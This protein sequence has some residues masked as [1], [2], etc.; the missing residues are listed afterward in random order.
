[1]FYKMKKFRFFI[2]L[3][4]LIFSK[5][6]SSEIIEI[7]SME[8]IQPYIDD[9]TLVV[10]DIDNTLLMTKQMLGG[11]QWFEHMLKKYLSEEFSITESI[12]KALPLYMEIQNATEVVPVEAVVPAL[13]HKL[14]KKGNLVIGLTA[15]GTAL[16]YKTAE[17]LASIGIHL[18]KNPPY[19]QLGLSSH[20]PLNYV[21]GILF[22]TRHHKGDYLFALAAELGLEI[23]KIVFV[24][25]K[26]CYL[27]EMEESCKGRRI[28]YVGFRYG[29][30][31]KVL[32][33]YD[34]EVAEM[35]MKY[36]GKIL[37]NEAAEI[38]LQEQEGMEE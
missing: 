32:Q 7:K 11:D 29:G 5:G 20:F 34:P 31:D 25:D 28:P 6:L 38:L 2:L 16:A 26:H 27:E 24:D 14:Q 15:R 35:Q 10:L 4:L 30:C 18:N 33:E 9:D 1:M 17:Q 36:F 19:S 23:K 13:I 8:E 37:S 3:L 22:V 12:A 21:E